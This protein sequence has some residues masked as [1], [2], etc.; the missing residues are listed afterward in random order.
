M[1][2]RRDIRRAAVVSVE[3]KM[4]RRADFLTFT[5]S[6]RSLRPLLSGQQPGVKFNLTGQI[7]AI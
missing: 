7:K 5:F 2:A 1:L 3:A 4:R 6:N